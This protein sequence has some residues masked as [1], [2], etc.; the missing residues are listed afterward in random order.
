MKGMSHSNLI[1]R[2]SSYLDGTLTDRE[3]QELEEYLAGHPEARR[4][5]EQLRGVSKLV[6]N[7][8]R[9]EP[10]PLFWSKLSRRLDET[11]GERENLLP[12]PRKY[13]PIAATLCAVAV[14][15]VGLLVVRQRVPVFRF[16][17][18]T[19]KEVQQAYEDNILKGTILPLFSGIDKDQVLQFAMFGTLPL[20][21]ESKTVLRVDKERGSDY[22]IEVGEPES[23]TRP[24]TVKG[25]TAHTA[26]GGEH[27]FH[28][29]RRPAA[30]S[31]V[32]VHR[33]EPGVGH[34]P[35]PSA[36]EQGHRLHYRCA[37]DA[38]GAGPVQQIP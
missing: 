8:K 6:G 13:L 25:G 19:T 31:G 24:V 21:S 5:L 14:L 1:K 30:H 29:R 11:R 10:D 37:A 32:R 20:D 26:A 7:Q 3:Q 33:G 34:R 12:F 15:M 16:L 28:P 22:S 18:D 2:L 35:E 9:L 17:Q 36:S 23:P 4:E 38:A 27:R